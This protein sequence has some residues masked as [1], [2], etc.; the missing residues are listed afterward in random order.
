MTV[1]EQR[2]EQTSKFIQELREDAKDTRDKAAQTRGV[3][4]TTLVGIIISIGIEFFKY[5][6]SNGSP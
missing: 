4:I 2:T 5:A 1:L 3:A 6:A